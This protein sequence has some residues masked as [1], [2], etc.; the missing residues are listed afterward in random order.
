MKFAKRREAHCERLIF[1]SLQLIVPMAI[2][3]HAGD[4]NLERWPVTRAYI[5]GELQP[6]AGDQLVANNEHK[7]PDG[8]TLVSGRLTIGGS[9][10]W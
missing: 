2:H 10:G 6:A 8:Y 3:S 5:D 9:H 4:V 7:R 1:T